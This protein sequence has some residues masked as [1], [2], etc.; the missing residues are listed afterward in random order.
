MS[1]CLALW[2]PA[3]R[4]SF[5]LSFI[6]FVFVAVLSREPK[7]NQGRGLVDR[8]LVQAPP[9]T[10]TPS[11]SNFIAGRPKAALL[12]GLLLVVLFFIIFSG[13]SKAESRAR[14]GRP[15]TSSSPPP[16][17]PVISLLA[18]PRCFF[19][20]GSLVILDMARCYLWLFSLYINMKIGKNIF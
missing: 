20:F 6:R 12:S 3:A 13:S 5:Y 10:H 11:A 19:C 16:P 18:V 4:F 14:A 17:P 7:Q 1:I 8:K 9:H 15:K 2:P